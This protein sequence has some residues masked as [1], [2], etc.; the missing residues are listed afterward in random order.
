M[1]IELHI[2]ELVLHGFKYGD[3]YQISEAI[4]GELVRLFAEQ[5]VPSS[6]SRNAEITQLDGNAFEVTPGSKPAAIGSQVAHAVYG[7]LGK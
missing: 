4:Q 6:L 2:K 3:R 1:N 7:G 5:G